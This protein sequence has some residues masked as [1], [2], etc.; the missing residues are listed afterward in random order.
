MASTPN[1]RLSAIQSIYLDALNNES[2]DLA[3][4]TTPAQVTAVQANVA[5][6][7][8]AYY[9]AAAAALAN[10]GP[11]VEAAYAAA[12]T[13]LMAVKQARA[14]SANITTLLGYLDGA[15]NAG[16]KLLKLSG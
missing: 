9:A 16:S 5:N 15:T 8:A 14:D 7:R 11:E 4:A 3:Q 12:Q 10:A 13:A 1:D 6:A 2:Q